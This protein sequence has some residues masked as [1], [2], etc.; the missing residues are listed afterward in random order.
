LKFFFT[1]MLS[2]AQGG[3]AAEFTASAIFGLIHFVND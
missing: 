3:L 1:G 2:Y